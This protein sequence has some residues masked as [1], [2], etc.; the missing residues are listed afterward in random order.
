M[1]AETFLV[2]AYFFRQLCFVDHPSAFLLLTTWSAKE[3]IKRLNRV[4]QLTGD[5]NIIASP[6]FS[7]AR[8]R[9]RVAMKGKILHIP[10]CPILETAVP[11][12]A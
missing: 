12:R 9:C 2:G 6:L 1:A 8:R 5:N 4:I 3:I 7:R 10:R 11:L